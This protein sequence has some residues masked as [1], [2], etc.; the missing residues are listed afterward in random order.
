MKEND[1]IKA[2]RKRHYLPER[3]RR[4]AALTLM[5]CSAGEIGKILDLKTHTVYCYFTTLAH[6]FNCETVA[7][8]RHKWRK[9]LNIYQKPT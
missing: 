6:I 7:E 1:I 2:L 4:I 9:N 3:L 5:G 8:F